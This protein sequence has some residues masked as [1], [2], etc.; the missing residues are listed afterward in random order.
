MNIPNIPLNYKCTYKTQ[1]NGSNRA[2][3]ICIGK[4]ANNHLFFG[5]VGSTA[6]GIFRKVNGTNTGMATQN[7]LT[8]SVEYLHTFQY[9]S[10]ALSLNVNNTTL[11]ANYTLTERDYVYLNVDSNN[12]IKELKIKPL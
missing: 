10:G 5:Q 11:T 2:A 4:D 7:V 1:Y 3:W 6:L 9:E 8:Q 12:H